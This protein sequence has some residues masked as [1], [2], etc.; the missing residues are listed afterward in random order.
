MEIFR[1]IL[2]TKVA[3]LDADFSFGSISNVYMVNINKNIR[4]DWRHLEHGSGLTGLD[5]DHQLG[6]HLVLVHVLDGLVQLRCLE[7]QSQ[8][9]F[10]FGKDLNSFISAQHVQS[11][12]LI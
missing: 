2:S 1:R 7:K 6:V 5:V 4:E 9:V 12:H 10:F 8:V 3:D 11:Y